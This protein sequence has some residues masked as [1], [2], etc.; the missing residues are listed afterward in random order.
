MQNLTTW[1]DRFVSEYTVLSGHLVDI[2]VLGQCLLVSEKDGKVLDSELHPILSEEEHYILDNGGIETLILKFGTNYFFT[3]LSIFERF[4]VIG[5]SENNFNFLKYFGKKDP[6]IEWPYLGVR[7]SYEILNGV[8]HYSEWVRKAKFLG[9]KTLGICE[10]NT[11]GGVLKFQL[12]CKKADIKPIIGATYSIKDERGSWDFK[13]YVKNKEGWRNLLLINSVVKVLNEQ[14]FI[15]LEEL[16]DLGEGLVFVFCPLYLKFDKLTI[17]KIQKIFTDVYYQ[18]E[19]SNFTSD[20]RDQEYLMNLKQWKDESNLKPVLICDSHYLEPEHKPLYEALNKLGDLIPPLLNNTRHFKDLEEV[21]GNLN[22]VFKDEDSCVDFISECVENTIELADLCTFKVPTEE[23]H[24]PQ[25]KMSAEEESMYKTNEGMFAALIEESFQRYKLEKGEDWWKE[26]ET[27]YRDRILVESDLILFGEIEDYFLILWDVIQYCNREGILVGTGRGSAAGSL[28][29]YLMGITKVNP[30]DWGLLFERFLTK[31]RL[32][33]EKG[34]RVS[35]PDIDVDFAGDRRDEVKRYLELK[36]GEDRV[37]S[38]GTYSSLQLK[39]GIKDLGRVKGLDQE[40]YNTFVKIMDLSTSDSRKVFHWTE[41]F[42]QATQKDFIKD[43]IQTNPDIIEYVMECIGQEKAVSVHPCATVVLPEGY[44]IYETFPVRMGEVAGHKMLISE[45][46]GDMIEKA[47]FLKEDILGVLQLTKFAMVQE[48]VKLQLNETLDVFKIPLDVPEVM[49]L[50]CKGYSS[51]VFQFQSQTLTNYTLQVQPRSVE[52]LALINAIIRPG[53]MDNGFHTDY[54]SIK[55]GE[56][57]EEYLSADIKTVLGE[58]KGLIVY[59]EQVMRVTQNIGGL[60]LSEA[61]EV[62]RAMGKLDYKYLSGFLPKFLDGGQEK[63]YKEDDLQLLWDQMSKFCRYAYNKCLSGD[64]QLVR[65]SNNKKNFH[66]T[67]SEM[68]AI[69]TSKAYS[70]ETGHLELHSKYN[71][72]GYGVCLSLREDGRLTNNRIKDIRFE[73]EKLVYKVTTESGKSIKSTMNHK[74]PTSNG[75]KK[76]EDIDIDKDFLYVDSG[77]EKSDSTYRFNEGEKNYPQKGEMG[78]QKKDSNFTKLEEFKKTSE[79]LC[80]ICEKV[81]V[82]RDKEIHHKDENHGNSE[83][84]NLQVLC[85]SCYKKQHKK[86]KPGEKGHL[87]H[88]EKIVSIEEVG[89]EEVYDIEMENPYHTLTVQSGIVTSN[90]HAVCYAITAYTSQYLKWKYPIQFWTTAFENEKDDLKIQRFISEIYKSGSIKLFGPDI[91]HSKTQFTSDHVK[92]EIYWTLNKVRE[93]GDVA[94]E[95]I[96]SE[97]DKNGEFFSLEEFLTRVPKGK[98]NKSVVENLIFSGAF[99]KLE[100]IKTV[101]ERIRL[102]KKFREL[103]GV[104]VD[105]DDFVEVSIKSGIVETDWWWLLV[106]KHVSGFAFFNYEDFIYESEDWRGTKLPYLSPEE[107][108][109]SEYSSGFTT[110]LSKVITSGVIVS[111]DIRETSVGEEFARIL[112]ENNYT[113]AWVYI[114]GFDNWAHNKEYIMGAGKGSLIILNAVPLNNQWVGQNVFQTVKDFTCEL[115][116]MK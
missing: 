78:F 23:W 39:A 36:Y 95:Q 70:K 52:E 101:S 115:L 103:R 80:E 71:R 32:V 5:N 13:L 24:I 21:M 45:W 93:C 3:D 16:Q 92:G 64:T 82:G 89:V 25:Y 48:L 54:V 2:A 40:S 46:E 67:I 66:P 33:D 102:I 38:I 15:S 57:Q 8:F 76:L 19:D 97:R 84:T 113:T 28:V 87:T 83:D 114:R 41:V 61:D 22:E 60:T 63:G 111:I 73:G 58:T 91:N 110:N 17:R 11:L 59:Q 75:E 44:N 53:P 26:H 81:L 107:L 6:I 109:Q 10:K 100:N 42:K 108:S 7:G 1:L 88:F 98:V 31:G 72:E 30:L 86:V 55:K 12:A 99:D 77:Y 68:Y 50:F 85:I 51:D 18:V 69:K 79:N 96:L 43:F 4:G 104:K 74:Y 105:K 29:S 106:Q 94:V 90:S 35:L 112:I 116:T 34:N 14:P 62:R 65:Y 37:C 27:E 47:G 20:E 9:T 49:E 56:K